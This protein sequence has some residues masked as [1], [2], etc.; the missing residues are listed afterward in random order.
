[1]ICKQIVI[2]SAHVCAGI[3]P[4]GGIYLLDLVDYSV[5]GFPLLFV[6][7]LES[8]ALAWIY[9]YERLAED[10]KL[11]LG[12]PP[13]IYWKAC[14]M[15]ITPVV[16]IV[17]GDFN[18][19]VRVCVLIQNSKFVSTKRAPV[20]PVSQHNRPRK[21]MHSHVVHNFSQYE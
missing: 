1:M 18:V 16:I 5:S 20:C 14:W 21:Y 13:N 4:Q 3:I 9:G 2:T 15:G 12:R 17:S 19:L 11:M 6:G 7:L 8:V 10:V